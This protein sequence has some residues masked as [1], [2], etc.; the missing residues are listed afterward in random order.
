MVTHLPF[1]E[2][3][4]ELAYFKL[5]MI[6]PFRNAFAVGPRGVRGEQPL[7][8]APPKN[9]SKTAREQFPTV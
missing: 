9:A 1:A 4:E 7:I 3:T 6:K 8:D 5:V 2:G